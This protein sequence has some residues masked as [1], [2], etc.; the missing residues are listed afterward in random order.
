MHNF[1]ARAEQEGLHNVPQNS[2]VRFVFG[3]L[4]QSHAASFQLAFYASAGLALIGAVACAVLVRHEP[5]TLDRPVFG[6]RSRWVPANAGVTTPALTRLP[7][8]VP[9]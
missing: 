7:P 8:E 5:R 3:D 2:V 1:I 4:V 6:R 9:R